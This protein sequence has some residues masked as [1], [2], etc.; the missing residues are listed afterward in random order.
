MLLLW[1]SKKLWW[2]KGNHQN[3]EKK[4]HFPP[5]P[6]ELW[7]KTNPPLPP[8]SSELWKKKNLN[9]PLKVLK[10]LTQALKPFLGDAAPAKDLVV[11][12]KTK[13]ILGGKKKKKNFLFHPK[14]RQESLRATFK[15]RISTD[16]CIQ[17]GSEMNT[18]A[19]ELCELGFYGFFFCNNSSEKCTFRDQPSPPE[20]SS[21]Q[22]CSSRSLPCRAG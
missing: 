18:A 11:E 16:W 22:P 15:T 3:S 9:F 13:R 2:W 4:T 8:K 10:A 14:L 6:S 12:G 17:T 20:L 5:K 19:G 1:R 7:G 21:A